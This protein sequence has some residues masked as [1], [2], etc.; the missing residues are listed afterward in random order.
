MLLFF[1]WVYI[2]ESRHVHVVNLT[3]LLS[4]VYIQCNRINVHKSGTRLRGESKNV[5]LITEAYRAFLQSPPQHIICSGFFILFSFQITAHI[6]ICNYLNVVFYTCFMYYQKVV[7]EYIKRSHDFCLYTKKE[8]SH[9][10]FY[11]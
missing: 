8:M 1:M 2:A 5:L 6:W 3:N 4:V 7:Q 9:V 10:L 11:V